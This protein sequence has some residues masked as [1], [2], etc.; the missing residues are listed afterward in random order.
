MVA[1]IAESAAAGAIMAWVDIG[2]IRMGGL[3]V[4]LRCG[5]LR[6]FGFAFFWSLGV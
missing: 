4:G 6:T 5:E 1:V 2:W 3:D